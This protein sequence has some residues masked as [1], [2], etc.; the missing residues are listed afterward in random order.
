MKQA[1]IP[2]KIV[3]PW[4]SSAP[5]T[6]ITNPIPVA[7]QTGGHAS[8]TDGY[9]PINSAQIAAGGIPP[10]GTDTNGIH[11][12]ETAWLRWLQAGGAPPIYD[13]SFQTSIGGYPNNSIVQS[14]ITAGTIWLST[15]DDNTSNPDTGGANWTRLL[16]LRPTQHLQPYTAAGVY[17]FTVPSG[18]Y[19]LDVEG[20]GA[21]GGGGGCASSSVPSS[22]GGGG[23][24]G[25]KICA[26]TPGQVITVIVGTGGPGGTSAPTNGTAG[27][28]TSFGSFFTCNGGAAGIANNSSYGLGGSVTGADFSYNGQNG[29]FGYNFGSVNRGGFG[30]GSFQSPGAIL[31]ALGGAGVNGSFPGSAGTG[32][33]TT[34]G[35]FAGGNGHDGAVFVRWTTLD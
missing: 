18:V 3:T 24:Y 27:T 32:T 13:S 31:G 17:S 26:V 34:A 22:G 28:A 21:G 15:A 7:P 10:W 29:D 1:D 9:P 11:Y 8:F 14:A 2:Y 19:S 33:S 16:P 12:V 20:W 6:N 25:R 23:G 30:G 4:A 35:G 5:G